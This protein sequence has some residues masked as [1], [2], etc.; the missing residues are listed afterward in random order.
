MTNLADLPITFDEERH[1]YRVGGVLVPNV[2]KIVSPLYDWMGVPPDVLDRKAKLGTAVHMATEF[3]DKGTLDEETVSEEVRGYLN[4]WRRFRAETGFMPTLNEQIVFHPELRY[5]GKLDRAG[6]FPGSPE[7]VDILDIKSGAEFDAHGVQVAGYA[8][9]FVAE[10]QIRTYPSRRAVYL[11]PDGTYRMRRFTDPTDYQTF[12]A[13]V[14][15]TN[16]R[17]R[18]EP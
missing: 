2:T 14:T 18:H 7:A 6:V 16:W 12:V 11:K 8:L 3:D 15:L 4:A 1:E 5:A 17:I 10:R 9:A 13:L